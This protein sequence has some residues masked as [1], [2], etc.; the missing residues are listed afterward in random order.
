MLCYEQSNQAYGKAG[1]GN[2]TETGNR[3]QKL[4]TEMETQPLRCCSPSKIHYP[5]ALPASS[6][7]LATLAS[8]SSFVMCDCLVFLTCKLLFMFSAIFYLCSIHSNHTSILHWQVLGGAMVGNGTIVPYN[9]LHTQQ[10]IK[11]VSG[12]RNE[13]ARVGMLA[14]F[15]NKVGYSHGQTATS[16]VPRP[17]HMWVRLDCNTTQ[18][19]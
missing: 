12:S 15:K 13:A 11:N 7:C 19:H 4:K 10:A 16:L 6:F 2:E 18:S 14:L 17:T 3:N 1:N 8:L 9:L 5:S